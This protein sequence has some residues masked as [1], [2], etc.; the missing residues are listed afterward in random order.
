MDSANAAIF[1]DQRRDFRLLDVKVG[2]TL[3]DFLHPNAVLLLI[4]LSSRRPDGWSAAGIEKPELD[5]DGVGHFAHHAAQ[6][7]DLP[8]EVTLGD[9]ADR[10]IARHLRDQI[11]IHR[12]HRGAQSEARAGPARFAAGMPSANDHN[13]V[14]HRVPL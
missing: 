6:R 4:A 13:V 12:D 2:L 8:D 11:G 5:S 9:S 10:R 7:V 14:Y 3:Q 1:N